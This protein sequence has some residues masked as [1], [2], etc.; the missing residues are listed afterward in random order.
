MAGDRRTSRWMRA[1]VW[2]AAFATSSLLLPHVGG[3]SPAPSACQTTAF[4]TSAGENEVVTIDVPTGAVDPN[5]I[6]LPPGVLANEVAV[7]PDGTTALVVLSG[8][9][10]VAVIDVASRSVTDL[11]DVGEDPQSIAITPDGAAAYVTNYVDGTVSTIDLAT[12]TKDPVDLDIGPSVQGVAIDDRGEVAAVSYADGVRT[13]DVP[14]RTVDPGSIDAGK[15]PAGL[16][17][18]PDGSTLFVANQDGDPDPDPSKS[19]EV[20]VLDLVTRT[21]VVDISGF[22]HPSDVVVTADGA[23]VFVAN[24]GNDYLSTI[25]V[26]SLTKDA[27]D[28]PAGDHPAALGLTPDGS[29]LYAANLDSADVTQVDVATR[30]AITDLQVG[31]GPAGVAFTPCADPAPTT[32][33]T[34]ATP[35]STSRGTT[36]PGAAARPV[37][38]SP[39]FTG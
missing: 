37:S 8:P 7:T 26:A 1:A 5:P 2:T 22:E 23:T 31:G 4:V 39:R 34:T 15:G 29:T 9:S 12:M 13:I 28:L 24:F 25:D 10:Q 32:T 27:A 16:A 30:D 33:T 35:P 6:A 38:A 17:F 21:N 3:A 18:T 20:S 36:P 14:T 19:G 11:V